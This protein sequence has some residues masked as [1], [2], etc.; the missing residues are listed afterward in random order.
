M[1]KPQK[2]SILVGGATG[3]FSFVKNFY[4]AGWLAEV[5]RQLAEGVRAVL[6]SLTRSVATFAFPEVVCGVP[7]RYIHA[8]CAGTLQCG[9]YLTLVLQILQMRRT[10]M[11]AFANAVSRAYTHGVERGSSFA[12]SRYSIAYLA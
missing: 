8:V 9:T 6:L 10:L 4:T 11:T 7:Q 5:H 3:P 12:S 1:L 2:S